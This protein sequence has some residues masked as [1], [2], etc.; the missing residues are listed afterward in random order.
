MK[1]LTSAAVLLVLATPVI[2]TDTITIEVAESEDLGQYL[3]DSDG[4]PV[5]VFLTDKRATDDRQA[6]ISCTS[7]ECIEA[8]PSV[9]TFGDPQAGEGV[10]ASLLSTTDHDSHRVV[11]YHGWPLYYSAEREIPESS[12][13]EAFGGE[14][15]LVGP[16]A[17]NITA[18]ITAGEA[19][20]AN[21]C[22]QCHGRTGRGM[23]SFPSLTGKEAGYIADL[24]KK[25]RA[26]ETV[27][28]NSALMRPVAAELVDDDIANV[29]TFISEEFR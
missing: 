20:Y 24:L 28:P 7:A 4:R 27:G 9:I 1:I 12:V 5:Y 26:G 15:T 2:A 8:W 18:D 17:V 14:W 29:S 21:S 13:I 11:T 22:A 16:E 25:Y 3:T 19:L 10:D 23:A 6:K